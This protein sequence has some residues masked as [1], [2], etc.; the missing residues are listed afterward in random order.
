MP[1]L[2]M[3]SKQVGTRFG[4]AATETLCNACSECQFAGAIKKDAKGNYVK[5][6]WRQALL[7]RVDVSGD[8]R[9][10][11]EN[12]NAFIKHVPCVVV[13]KGTELFHVSSSSAWV[14]KSVVG[15]NDQ[16]DGY[17]FFTLRAKGFAAAHENN[18]TARIQLRLREDVHGF[19]MPAYDFPVY[20]WSDYDWGNGRSQKKVQSRNIDKGGGLVATIK[21]AWPGAIRPRLL[22][23]CSECELIIHSSLVPHVTETVAAATST[24]DF[25]TRKIV[26]FGELPASAPK[27]TTPAFTAPAGNWL[28]PSTAGDARAARAAVAA[29]G[30][31]A[32]NPDNAALFD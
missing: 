14:R 16:D 1:T 30:R 10:A 11:R 13:P 21:E 5:G 31:D 26:P 22:I 20:E 15:A 29:A 7:N 4:A 8:T 17:A 27:D 23:G 18:F 6:D 3:S 2:I 32:F 25:K 24:D 12:V 28:S 19:F 9:V